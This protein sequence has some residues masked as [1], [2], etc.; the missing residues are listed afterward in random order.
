MRCPKC[1][2]NGLM[3][4]ARRDSREAMTIQ[5]RMTE[6]VD[7][8]GLFDCKYCEG[9][10]VKPCGTCQGQGWEY[11]PF[12]NY[13]KFQPHPVF[14]QY[15]WSRDKLK[16]KPYEVEKKIE[17]AVLNKSLEQ[18]E[19]SK[20]RNTRE[21]RKAA[22]EVEKKRKEAEKAAK[23]KAARAKKKDLQTA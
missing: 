3:K 23:R 8:G 14:E 4:R 7:D 15:H 13:R 16:Q 6:M 21:E 20:S 2:G 1:D 10:G 17:K 12:V 19:D 18:I 5:R 9:K 22:K 11:L